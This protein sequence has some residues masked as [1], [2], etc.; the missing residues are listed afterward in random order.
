M[1]VW[2][3]WERSFR[4][5]RAGAIYVGSSFT[6]SGGILTISHSKAEHGGRMWGRGLG[7]SLSELLTALDKKGLYTS[8]KCIIIPYINS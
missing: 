2:K 7:D 1:L 8:A 4:S 6:Q 5:R 3:L